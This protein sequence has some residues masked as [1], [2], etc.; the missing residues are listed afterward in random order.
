[1]S[2]CVCVFVCM[3]ECVNC[4]NITPIQFLPCEIVSEVIT[5]FYRNKSLWQCDSVAARQ[6][7]RENWKYHHRKKNFSVTVLKRNTVKVRNCIHTI[8]PKT[9]LWNIFTLV[10]IVWFKV[11]SY[12]WHYESHEI[13]FSLTWQGKHP[14][15]HRHTH[16]HTTER[17]LCFLSD[18][19]RV[20]WEFI[21]QCQVLLSLQLTNRQPR[22]T[23]ALKGCLL[24]HHFQRTPSCP[25]SVPQ[26]PL[27]EA[28]FYHT[29]PFLRG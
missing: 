19:K 14:L 8:L 23:R 9:D 15:L 16:T 25:S 3:C 1:M 2:V 20:L 29:S 7:V 12:E 17:L 28:I 24:F 13:G 6:S 22:T 26:P 4:F 10:V 27:V 11:W 18:W 5:C 21:S